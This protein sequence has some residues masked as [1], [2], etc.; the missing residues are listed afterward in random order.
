MEEG[1]II[2]I[3]NNP[4]VRIRLAPEVCQVIQ[5]AMPLKLKVVVPVEVPVNDPP[6]PVSPID[7][8]GT[9]RKTFFYWAVA[10]IVVRDLQMP[11]ITNQFL[12]DHNVL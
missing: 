4:S 8:P 2:E 3:N 7:L 10:E 5:A 1:E 12:T 11:D 9:R 6:R